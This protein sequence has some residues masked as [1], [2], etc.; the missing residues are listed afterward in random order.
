[1]VEKEVI[2]EVEKPVVVEKEVIR[3]VE[4][5]V[6][7]E[8]EVIREVEKPVVVEKEV[9]KEVEVVKEVVKEVLVNPTQEI[10][11]KGG[12]AIEAM[13]ETAMLGP[14]V[15]AASGTPIL[16]GVGVCQAYSAPTFFDVHRGA[17]AN[18]V[19]WV[20]PF[21]NGLIELNPETDDFFDVRGDLA[22]SW[23]VTPDGLSYVFNLHPDATWWD[24]EPVTAE[25]AV[26]SLDRMVDSNE[27]RP[28]AGLI[29]PY[30]KGS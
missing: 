17:A 27:S 24:G 30:Y 25:D 5:P 1:V 28:R 26:W 12:K 3:E 16:G 9:I 23:E 21:Y 18:D 13:S 4:K 19:L 6:V 15:P 2:K 8:K 22:T 20:S 11:L 14:A 10:T 29:K 7:V